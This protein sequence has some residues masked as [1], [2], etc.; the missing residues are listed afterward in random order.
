MQLMI[1]GLSPWGCLQQHRRREHSHIQANQ[2]GVKKLTSEVLTDCSNL[3]PHSCSMREKVQRKLEKAGKVKTNNTKPSKKQE[4]KRR[5][6][7]SSS[8]EEI[9]QDII[10][11]VLKRI[12]TT[13]FVLCI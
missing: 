1:I 2:P 5:V 13:I 6:S 12:I 9:P 7:L 8:S 11:D 4:K 10:S 3:F